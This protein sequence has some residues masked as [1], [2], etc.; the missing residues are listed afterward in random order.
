MIVR[1]RSALGF[2]MPK[3]IISCLSLRVRF[4]VAVACATFAGSATPTSALE[5]FGGTPAIT[6][7]AAEEDRL[8]GESREMTVALRRRGMVMPQTPY[9]DRLN[10]LMRALYPEF[11]DSITVRI[12]RDIAPNAFALPNGDVYVSLGLLGR[13]ENEA[14]IAMVL[15]HEGAHFVH[16]HSFR[17]RNTRLAVGTIVGVVGIAGGAVGSLA[18]LGGALGAQLALLGGMA[19]HG[20]DME[21]EA[22]HTGFQRF[23]KLGYAKADARRAFELLSDYAK[24]DDSM[25]KAF[26]FASH[27]QLQERIESIDGAAGGETATTAYDRAFDPL[28]RAIRL[29]WLPQEIGAGRFKATVFA[30]ENEERRASMPPEVDFYLSE[31]YRLRGEANDTQLAAE[32]LARAYK[33]TPDYPPVLR[34][35]GLAAMRADKRQDAKTFFTLYLDRSPMATDRAFIESYLKQLSE[36]S[37]TK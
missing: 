29:Q 27:P 1:S 32:W 17:G 33:R 36:E 4:V 26:L 12:V 21:R 13:L 15:A 19:G 35:A 8:W 16:R 20:R 7:L 30:L 5:P 34:A 24:A 2:T 11:G 10:E 28:H 31:A 37:T 22:D 23:L 18:A 14:Q 6:D 9:V 3:P 25:S